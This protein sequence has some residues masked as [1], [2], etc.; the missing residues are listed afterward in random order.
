MCFHL[1]VCLLC[2]KGVPTI[3]EVQQKESDILKLGVT[4]GCELPCG[5]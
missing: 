5:V 3:C 1:R 4:N 2:T